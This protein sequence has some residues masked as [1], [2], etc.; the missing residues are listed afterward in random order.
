MDSQNADVYI[1]YTGWAAGG[2]ST[3][4]ELNETYVT[5]GRDHADPLEVAVEWDVH[6]NASHVQIL[7]TLSFLSAFAK[8]C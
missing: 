3:T 4:Y 5:P 2:F 7:P 6:N 8:I 1:G